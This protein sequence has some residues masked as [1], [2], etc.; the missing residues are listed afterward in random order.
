MAK[1]K[2][3]TSTLRFAQRKHDFFSLHP[4]SSSGF[5]TQRQ[6]VSPRG[7]HSSSPSTSSSPPSAPP[8]TVITLADVMN[9]NCEARPD[10]GNPKVGSIPSPSLTMQGHTTTGKVGPS[11]STQHHTGNT[12][13]SSPTLV[14]FPD[15]TATSSFEKQPIRQEIRGEPAIDPMATEAGVAV[16][17]NAGPSACKRAKLA[18]TAESPDIPSSPSV[19]QVS[20]AYTT[21]AATFPP[22][23]QYL[24]RS[25]AAAKSTFGS[26]GTSRRQPPS[27][28][29]ADS[30]TQGSTTSNPSS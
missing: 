1:S 30:R 8:R 2:K 14:Y 10:A 3:K 19:V 21:D 23:R 20:G 15:F 29:S 16:D 18:A 5:R 17:K 26:T 24:T 12:I 4:P 25:R 11:S 13:P 7:Q 28:S 27:H 9:S 6:S 22:M